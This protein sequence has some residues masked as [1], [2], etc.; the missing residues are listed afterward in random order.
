MGWRKKLLGVLG[1]GVATAGITLTGFTGKYWP[2]EVTDKSAL[3][4]VVETP[5]GMEPTKAFVGDTGLDSPQRAAVV[6]DLVQLCEA[7]PNG[8]LLFVPG[9]YQYPNGIY[10][11]ETYKSAIPPFEHL[12]KNHLYT[13]GSPGNHDHYQLFERGYLS[14]RMHGR[15]PPAVGRFVQLNY[16]YTVIT[17]KECWISNDSSIYLAWLD[18]K[19]EDRQEEYDEWSLRANCKGRESGYVA[20]HPFFSNGKRSPTRDYKKFYNETISDE[21]LKIRRV[22]TGHDHFTYQVIRDQILHTVSGMGSKTTKGVVG[23][24]VKYPGIEVEIRR[25]GVSP[26]MATDEED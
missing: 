13:F 19:I 12:C 22:V 11:D 6:K 21:K 18:P 23:Y 3:Q 17:P 25:V 14:A 5:T 24:A 16:Y 2:N 15:R 8:F 4:F 20:H 7:S 10:N 1:I 26:T 9:D